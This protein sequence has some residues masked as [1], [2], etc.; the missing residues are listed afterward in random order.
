MET[1]AKVMMA[2]SIIVPLLLFVSSGVAR[3]PETRDRQLVHSAKET[4]KS[5]EAQWLAGGLESPRSLIQADSD[6]FG[7]GAKELALMASGSG[8][9][10]VSIGPNRVADIRRDDASTTDSARLPTILINKTYDPTN[11][12]VSQ[13]DIWRHLPARP[14]RG[15]R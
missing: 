5:I 12:I 13:G 10:L 4:M 7:T 6:P 3:W 9:L 15:S 14:N 11:G 8:H 1:K 2:L